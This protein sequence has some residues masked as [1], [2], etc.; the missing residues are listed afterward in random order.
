MKKIFT[1]IMAL[2]LALTPIFA[3]GAGAP[4]P[5]IASKIYSKPAISFSLIDYD[6][7][8]EAL[9]EDLKAN[10]DLDELCAEYITGK[11]SLDEALY[12]EVD[13]QYEE[14]IWSFIP[15]YDFEKQ[16]VAIV[17]I[18]DQTAAQIF[19]WGTVLED[20]SVLVDFSD[21]EPD[22]YYMFVI[23]GEARLFN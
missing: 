14:V 18:G 19:K 8:F 15:Q 7:S 11:W 10:F 9:L 17:F 12:I 6:D 21:I 16:A 1:I 13:Q 3:L 22:L 5:S 4:S 20:G 2:L 23:S